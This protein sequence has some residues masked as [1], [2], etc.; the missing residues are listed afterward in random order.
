MNVHWLENK[1]FY[2][3]FLFILIS[4]ILLLYLKVNKKSKYKIDWKYN[5]NMTGR[6]KLWEETS[7]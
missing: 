5:N 1:H 2:I 6:Y 4:F 3:L 7:E